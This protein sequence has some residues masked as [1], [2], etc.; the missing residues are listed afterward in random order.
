MMKFSLTRSS[1]I[2]PFLFAVIPVL[3]LVSLNIDEVRLDNA[4]LPILVIIL[5]TVGMWYLFNLLFK[6]KMKSGLIVSISLVLFFM[7]GHIFNI[8]VGVTIGDFEIG[9]HRYLMG[10]FILIFAASVYFIFKA[11]KNFAEFTTIANVIAIVI[12]LLSISNI[13]MSLV[14]NN[15]IEIAD[16]N[17]S[18]DTLS[19][20]ALGYTPN[21]YYIILDE[22]T[23]SKVLKEL[24]N[25]DNQDFISELE[26]RGFHVGKNSHSNYSQTF[27]SVTSSLNMEYLNYLADTV[28]VDSSDNT[29]PL[30]LWND[31]KISKIFKSLNYTVVHTPIYPNTITSHDY[32][33]C[34]HSLLSNQFHILLWKSTISYTPLSVIFPQHSSTDQVLCKFSELSDLHNVIEKPF[35][36]Y[37]HFLSPHHPYLFGS[38]GEIKQSKKIISGNFTLEDKNDYVEQVQFI[39]KKTIETIDTILL[40]STSPPIIILQG[41]HGTFSL[42]TE[43]H[44]NWHHNPS[45][46]AIQERMSILNAYYLPDQ[47]NKLIYDGITPVNSFRLILN[48]YFNGDFELLGDKNYFSGYTYPYNFINVTAILVTNSPTD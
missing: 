21:V 42:F 15:F 20:S 23:N 5:T 7:Y 8:F 48:E 32:Q 29:L 14:E 33:L 22:Y 1:V 10:S 11:K 31:N 19:A 12:V 38:N 41:D 13:T 34:P 40:E 16:N 44:K 45:D 24:F 43:P 30:K 47:N 46:A 39:N 6:N 35:F 18:F 4:V 37:A 3:L 2:H 25:F 17:I 36:V 9:R 26:S 27:L 28:G